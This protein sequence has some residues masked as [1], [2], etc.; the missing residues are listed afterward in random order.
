VISKIRARL[1]ELTG[2]AT[3]VPILLLFVLNLVDEFDQVAFG[4]FAPEIR[5]TFGISDATFT[6][7]TT[8]PG[9]LLIMLIVPV[10]VLADRYNRVKLIAIAAVAWGSMTI[11]TG[12]SGFIG[13]GVLAL[14]ILARLGSGLG[15]LMNEPV[16]ASLLADYY[17][18][19]THGRV[20]A[21]HRLA[22]PI[23][24]FLILVGGL[25]G[26][27]FGWRVAFMLLAIP[28]FA[29]VVFIT[30]LKEPVR[31]ASVNL[32]LA[33]QAE[34]AG[35]K[36]P[37][38][39]GVRRL[40]AIKTFKR[41]WIAAFFLGGPVLA[42]VSFFSFFF[43]KV[44]GVESPGVWG[45]GGITALYS[46][47]VFTGTVLWG[48]LSDKTIGQFKLARMAQT[49]GFALG[50]TAVALVLTAVSPFL[51]LSIF[52]VVLVGVGSAGFLA[53]HLPITALVAPPRLRSLG[54]ALFG[55]WFGIGAIIMSGFVAGIGENQ[56]Y[57]W[58]IA[59]LAVIVAFAGAI[60]AS[61]ARFVERDV[62]QALNSLQAEAGLQSELEASGSQA[63][64]LCR[65]VEVAYDQVQVLFGVDMEVRPGEIVAL[66]GTNGAGKSTLLRA[67]SGTMD[68]IGGAIF[69]DGRDITH[70]DAQA[71]VKLGIVQVPGGKAVFPT[72]TVAEHLRAAG[73]LYRDDPEYLKTATEEVLVTFP[74]L[75]E[76]IDQ[77]AGNLSGGEQQMLALGMAFIA[78]P[79]LLMIDELSLG[80]APTIVE[81]LLGIVRRI[82]EQGTA[83][84]L[85]EQ[86]INVALSV[87]E[88]AYFLEKGEVRFEGPTAELIERDDIV[89]SVFLQGAAG[90]SS[91][92]AT[93]KRDSI[94]RTPIGSTVL[95]LDGL[96]KRFGGITAVDGTTFHL[97]E[98]EILGLIGPNGAGKTTIFD[99]I[100]GFL[101]PDDGRITFDGVDVTRMS[102]D[103]RAWL[104]LGRSF[105]DARLV[106]SLT[107]AE[108]IAI[109]L[110]RFIAVRD[111]IASALGLPGVVR[112]EEDVAWTV[113]DLIELMNLGAYRDKFVR[114]L[115][116]GTRRIVDLAM[117]IGHDPKVLLLDEPS[118]G[119]AQRETE[120][121]GP[122]LHRIQREAGCALLVIEHDMPLITSISDRM[123]ALE[124]GRPIVEGTPEEVTT[125][126]TVVSS[127]LGGD[128]ATINRSGTA[129]AG[130]AVAGNGT[131]RTARRTR[132]R[133]A[134]QQE[135]NA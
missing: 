100:S 127:Y 52:F 67:I 6:R 103:K 86:S 95:E 82:Q 46:A 81:Q 131:A 14:L 72:L 27:L 13:G 102:P 5:D 73:W 3:V 1:E 39:E 75:R 26:Q 109:G 19:S 106:P 129:P 77:M 28:T 61:A 89:R 49:G 87:A 64:L 88:R 59:V 124:L 55:F 107:V 4:V 43:E 116:T 66:L 83:I 91:E 121:L 117:C 111:P 93:V 11:L 37:F 104:G 23:G 53:F 70:T 68:P 76:R 130:I 12:A 97:R 119:I 128:L 31:G 84:I 78:K 29:A 15:R 45:R 47:G 65:G 126:P 41:F 38:W 54:F 98:H 32:S 44:Y 16:H 24:A 9:A 110:E 22:N 125:D 133:T 58:G 135:T 79:K 74:R 94:E 51:P 90:G 92:P 34:A 60:Y 132:R 63:L 33:K 17:E 134:S 105:Q 10:G 113:A 42:I 7:I 50:V 108:N 56:G 115:S 21:F 114:E 123:I 20:Y 18:P 112:A 101:I 85:V 62:Q 2:G 25:L 35:E 30:R 96:V 8:V 80:L 36:I 118:S 69:F 122:L 48:R 71:T 40:S 120:A 57:R 99:L